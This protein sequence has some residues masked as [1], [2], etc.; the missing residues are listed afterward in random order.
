MSAITETAQPSLDRTRHQAHPQCVVC[1]N[2]SSCALGLRFRLL[3]NGSV[4]AKFDCPDRFQ[5]YPSLLY[6]GVISS[7]LDRA[8]TNC[9]FAHGVMAV[10]A[11]LRIRFRHPVRTDTSSTITARI[12]RCS[13]P[14]YIG[15]A[16]LQQGGRVTSTAT[17]KFMEKKPPG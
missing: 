4:E 6:G 14:L 13:P 10:T 9:L 8:I 7:L 17:G 5:G 3:D 2:K 16:E 12:T 1:G 11:E 15:Q